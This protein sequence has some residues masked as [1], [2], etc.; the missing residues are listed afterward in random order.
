MGT[1]DAMLRRH[2]HNPKTEA[3]GAEWFALTPKMI[4]CDPTEQGVHSPE[5]ETSKA[6]NA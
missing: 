4:R 5:Q 6:A 3:E 1:S 2:Y